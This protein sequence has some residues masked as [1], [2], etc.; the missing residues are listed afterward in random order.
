MKDYYHILGVHPKAEEE[1]IKAAYNGLA[2]KYHPDLNPSADAAERMKEINEAYEVL[3]D[4]ARRADYEEAYASH[5]GNEFSTDPPVLKVKPK[6]LNFGDLKAGETAEKRL[7]V[8]NHGGP[9]KGSLNIDESQCRDWATVN[10]RPLVDDSVFPLEVMV[11]IDT[12]DL[13]PG[14]TYRARILLQYL[15][16]EIAIPVRVVILASGSRAGRSS[17]ARSSRRT[18]DP[19]PDLG[20]VAKGFGVLVVLAAS[21][22]AAW[23]FCISPAI[24]WVSD[25]NPR[26]SQ[27]QIQA[28]QQ[29]ATQSALQNI[30]VKTGGIWYCRLDSEDNVYLSTIVYLGNVG[31]LPHSV[32]IVISTHK[33]SWSDRLMFLL[34]SHSVQEIRTPEWEVEWKFMDP[35]YW[36]VGDADCGEVMASFDSYGHPVEVRILAFDGVDVSNSPETTF[37]FNVTEYKKLR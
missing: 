23:F 6:T 18:S 14:E 20:D 28:T 26:L 31:D 22:V 35:W 19:D 13:S 9:L 4:P 8:E 33:G 3:G 5:F 11:E 25:S 15:D 29:A 36:G 17:K 34:S 12:T 32:D 10:A 27:E 2:K 7:V 30:T 1:V 21:L 16:E 37:T 24:S